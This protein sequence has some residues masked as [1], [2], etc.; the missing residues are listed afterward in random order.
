MRQ[1]V[2]MLVARKL[3]TKSAVA[4]QQGTICY[5]PGHPRTPSMN[6][7]RPPDAIVVVHTHATRRSMLIEPLGIRHP[8]NVY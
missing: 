7:I 1:Y 2:R 8:K 3:R 6:A 4:H 5:M